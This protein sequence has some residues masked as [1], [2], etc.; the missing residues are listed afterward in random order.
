MGCANSSHV[1]P[2]PPSTEP[3]KAAQPAEP[4][5]PCEELYSAPAPSAVAHS[6]AEEES[7]SWC[8]HLQLTP[9]REL[10]AGT[11]GAAFEVVNE[12]DGFRYCLKRVPLPDAAAGAAAKNEAAL[13]A[14]LD[15]PGC[16][17][18]C[19]SWID[20]ATATPPRFCLLMELCEGDLWSFLEGGPMIE[21]PDRKR[22]SDQ[23]AGAIAHVH[24]C[25]VV[26]RD[27]NPWNVMTC[28][29]R[30]GGALVHL[31]LGDFGLSI[32]C[33][34]GGSLSGLTSTDG[35]APLDESA[36]TSLYSAPELGSEAY[37]PPVDV[38]SLGATLYVI[39]AAAWRTLDGITDDVEALRGGT[40]ATELSSSTRGGEAAGETK[41][42]GGE[43]Q[44]GGLTA[45]AGVIDALV[46]A[47]PAARPSAAKAHR[48]I[49]SQPE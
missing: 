21:Y 35:A 34:Q 19:Y 20:G 27:V 46:A 28:R 45:M 8:A 22:W 16:V 13:H 14:R 7:G 43:S 39:W 18:Y 33:P 1:A 6:A 48:M 25:G 37:G 3:T 11:S 9:G 29:G 10:G 40:L 17:R 38:Y 30:G 31:K 24:A 42:A 26:H 15:H 36:L 2:A 49:L 32:Q 23:L 4:V 47:D 44:S 41:S 5:K 12:L